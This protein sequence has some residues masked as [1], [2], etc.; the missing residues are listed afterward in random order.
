MGF[1]INPYDACVANKWID[2]AQCTITWHIDDLKISHVQEEVLTKIIEDLKA[3]FGCLGELSVSRGR[4]HD[5]FGMYLDY[6]KDGGLEVDMRL[7]LATILDDLPKSMQGKAQSPAANHL[8][9][10]RDNATKLSSSEAEEFHRTMQLSYL[11]Q[12][13]RPDIRTAVAF[14]STRVASPDV[15]D[16]RKLTRVLKYLQS[17]FDLTL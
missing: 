17:S 9:M 2:G 13:G 8:T 3:E 4:R 7:Y 1:V 5:Y 14:L 15:D 12:R 10:I 6:S 16:K 11:A